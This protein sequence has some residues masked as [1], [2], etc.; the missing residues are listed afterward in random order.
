MT[1]PRSFGILCVVA[2]LSAVVAAAQASVQV[3]PP[4][5][6]G[7]RTLEQQTA[8]AAVHNYLQ[9]WASL[10]SAFQNNDAS[11]L[12]P[13]FIGTAK[14]KLSAT[15]G[16]QDN[17]KIRTNYQDRAHTIQIVFYSP[18]GL[19][20]ELTDD[21]EYDLQLIDH[22]KPAASQHMKAHYIVVMT[23]SETRWKVRVFQAVPD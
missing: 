20:L 23:P 15:I 13:D 7:P 17:L 6:S 3:K 5:V 12:D 1:T 2:A 9:A 22:D 19:S 4:D 11:L 16:Q 10:H 18:E 14:E 21:V 8:T